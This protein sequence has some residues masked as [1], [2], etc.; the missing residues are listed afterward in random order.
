M[1]LQLPAESD[2]GAILAAGAVVGQYEVGVAA[3]QHRQLAERVGHG[4]VRPGHLQGTHRTHEL[5]KHQGILKA[6]MHPHITVITVFLVNTFIYS[7]CTS[8]YILFG[9]SC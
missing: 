9:I 8:V 2:L 6:L 1:L 4:L 3:V 5:T 7:F